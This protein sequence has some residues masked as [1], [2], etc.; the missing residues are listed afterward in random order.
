MIKKSISIFKLKHLFDIFFLTNK[1]FN[2]NIQFSILSQCCKVHY[3]TLQAF[4][5]KSKISWKDHYLK[6][7]LILIS[8]ITYL[9][10]SQIH[11][12]ENQFFSQYFESHFNDLS[13][14]QITARSKSLLNLTGCNCIPG[15]SVYCIGQGNVLISSTSIPSTLN[16]GYIYVE[17]SLI[18]N[19]LQELKGTHLLFGPNASISITNSG[20]L[21]VNSFATLDIC[22][23]PGQGN[24]AMWQGIIIQS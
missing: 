2:M 5:S 9:N 10:Q 20:F 15:N 23:S 1:L 18:I 24:L 12:T 4:N 3:S 8:L 6:K 22:N 14:T 19:R 11:A 17:G 7:F 16:G 13:I 21:N